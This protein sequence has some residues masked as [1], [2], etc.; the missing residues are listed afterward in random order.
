MKKLIAVCFCMAIFVS[1]GS[2]RKIASKRNYYN[3]ENI[4][5]N[6]KLKILNSD[7]SGK[8]DSNVRKIIADAEKYLG[9]PY[10]YAGNS[11]VGFDCSGF[12]SKVFDE[13]KI[14]L[15]RRS[16][17]QGKMGKVINISDAKPGDLVFFST[18]G[19]D[20]SHVGI[21]YEIDRNGEVK[22]IHASTSKGV[23][24]SS[25]NEK[26]WNNAYLFTRRIL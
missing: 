6:E 7:F 14:K 13:N 11:E 3:N 23:I 25:L 24:I 18:F 4:K 8:S 9:V 5:K 15:P 21:I 12:T 26:Y 1:C 17:E 2:S 20:V 22:F 19:G 10:K 16:Q